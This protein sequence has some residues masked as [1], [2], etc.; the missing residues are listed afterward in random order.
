M[1]PAEQE[2][3]KT[4]SEKERK[5][6]EIAKA[7]LGSSFDLVKSNGFM[8]WRKEKELTKTL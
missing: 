6:Y 2:Y 3:L 1:T 5:S 4:L 7:H 8:K